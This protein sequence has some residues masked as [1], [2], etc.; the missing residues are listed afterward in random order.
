MRPLT[1]QTRVAVWSAVV[2]AT[3][4]LLCG[5]AITFVA[6]HEEIEELDDQLRA[7]AQRVFDEW[8]RHGGAAKYDLKKRPGEIREWLSASAP[9][10]LVEVADARD[11]VIYRSESLKAD[12]LGGQP[13]GFRYLTI[14]GRPWRF[15]AF[16][17]DGIVLRIAADLEPVRELMV[18]LITAFTVAIPVLLAFVVISG[19]WIARQ[20]L[21]PV[22]RITASAERVTAESP[23][24]RVPVPPAR[25]EI[26]R[27]AIVLNHA[28]DRL[29]QSFQQAQRFS[30]DASHEL[31]TPLT[32]L[33]SGLESILESGTVD[34]A[35][36]ETLS[37]LLEQ[38][39]RLSSITDSLLLLSRADAGRLSLDLAPA[40]ISEIITACVED[41]RII[42]ADRDISLEADVPPALEATVD[43]LR[44]SQIVV[45]LIDNAVKYNQPGGRVLV[46]ARNGGPSVHL[47]V[48][49]TG[50]TIPPV[51]ARQIF[52]RFFR[53]DANAERFGHG[54]G[55]SLS[56]ELVHAHH[57]VLELVKSEAGWTEFRVVVPICAEAGVAVLK[58]SIE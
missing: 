57:G 36:Q 25:D 53:G 40:N 45:N 39:Q 54:L 1:I 58:E 48:S 10:R 38:T 27:L 3:G 4:M 43:K 15:A 23:H 24:E 37:A 46:S 33:R 6:Y 2:I 16:A 9:P 14:E 8:H 5:A 18:N 49:N 11:S 31:K 12:W 32:V 51:H 30:A 55:L 34:S 44:F 19:R 52:E 47:S 13:P 17:R 20:A 26:Q 28:F 21:E 50:P 42:A 35:G 29:K 7:E 56:R 41:A 22:R